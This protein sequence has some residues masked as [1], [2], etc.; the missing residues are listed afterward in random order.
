MLVIATSCSRIKG[1]AC[2]ARLRPGEAVTKLLKDALA[3]VDV[4]TLDHVVVAGSG[5]TS[6]AERG[7]I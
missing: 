4:R 1:G 5:T 3:L 6:F 7:L 2:L